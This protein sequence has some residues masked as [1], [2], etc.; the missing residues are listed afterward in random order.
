MTTRPRYGRS[1][2][3][4]QSGKAGS[5]FLVIFLGSIC[6][7][8]GAVFEFQQKGGDPNKLAS[9]VKKR[10]DTPEGT[11]ETARK[12]DPTRK[13]PERI[14]KQP[15]TPRPGEKAP[16]PQPAPKPA[17]DTPAVAKAPDTPVVPPS[18]PPKPAAEPPKPVSVNPRAI[19][20][21][22]ST[23]AYPF[24]DV[25]KAMREAEGHLKAGRF[26]DARSC[27]V[28]FEPSR[29]LA[30]QQAEFKAL[31][32]RCELHATL[33]RETNLTPSAEPPNLT[34]I[35][36]RVPKG[37]FT[38]SILSQNDKKVEVLLLSNIAVTF[39]RFEILQ[40]KEI[41]SLRSKRLVESEFE[42]R[43]KRL[44]TRR[45]MDAFRL[46][47]FCLR[48]GMLEK[49]SECFDT[50]A[51]IAKK[52]GVDLVE[53]VREEKAEGLYDT[54]VFFL[55]IGNLRDARSTLELLR[56][57]YKGSPCIARA[58]DMERDTMKV[59][60]AELSSKIKPQEVEIVSAEVVPPG[61]VPAPPEPKT[62]DQ[63]AAAKPAPQPPA[64]APPP[65][66][67]LSSLP[68]D[69][70]AAFKK[71]VDEANA[72]YDQA[73]EHLKRSD[74]SINPKNWLKENNTAQ[75]LLSKAYALYN[76]ALDI[77]NDSSLWD[78][79][80]DTNFKRVLCRKRQINR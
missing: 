4:S 16:T 45:P 56:L 66:P 25:F 67:A 63:P 41:G 72:F 78:R 74:P 60:N 28:R 42:R 55:S 61:A 18:S 8:A 19:P 34:E 2:G 7:V 65:P 21:A 24:A 62:P 6:G 75:D 15:A 47:E 22:S 31:R 39:E 68:A 27:M 1:G 73:L 53:T 11:S 40:M 29:V 48:N 46:A 50:S 23:E 58:E 54:F 64:P 33:L 3:G 49:V 30:K 77:H 59:A 37:P 38:G 71:C 10:F 9:A 44:S 17:P 80:R 32:E 36:F 20:P 13:T 51:A 57:R 43:K 35:E 69:K 70:Q 79:V 52:V 5:V 76:K 14:A 12:P 26:D